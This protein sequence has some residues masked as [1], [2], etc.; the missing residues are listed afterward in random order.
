MCHIITTESGCVILRL[1][2][3]SL[4]WKTTVTPRAFSV[5]KK[6]KFNTELEG[7]FVTLS[8]NFSSQVQLV[9]LTFSATLKLKSDNYHY[10]SGTEDLFPTSEPTAITK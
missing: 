5:S 6:K 9:F 3:E 8:K 4:W 10:I 1:A 2:T 7:L